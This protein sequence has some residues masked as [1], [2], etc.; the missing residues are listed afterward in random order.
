MKREELVAQLHEIQAKEQE[1]Q[2]QLRAFDYESKLSILKQYEGKYYKQKQDVNDL[3]VA[4][5]FVHNI[6]MKNLNPEA[7]RLSYW[8][9][10]ETYFQLQDY[11]HFDPT[12]LSNDEEWV[13]ITKQEFDQCF[14]EVMKRINKAMLNIKDETAFDEEMHEQMIAKYSLPKGGFDTDSI[15]GFSEGVKIAMILKRNGKGTVPTDAIVEG[16]NWAKEKLSV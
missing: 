6:G 12:D 11:A 1:I 16:Y 7:I 3:H 8:T 13:E 15:A 14:A 9:D 2:K 4:C 10:R 5:I